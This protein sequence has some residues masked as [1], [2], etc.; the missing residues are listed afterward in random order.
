MAKEG[1]TTIYNEI[2]SQEKLKEVNKENL[3]LEEDFKKGIWKEGSS[4]ERRFKITNKQSKWYGKTYDTLSQED[5]DFFDDYIFSLTIFDSSEKKESKK[6]LYM[7][8]VFERIN[9]GSMKLSEQEVRNAVYSGITIDKIKEIAKSKSFVSLTKN[10]Q[11]ITD[12]KKDE[13]IVLR[14][15]TYYLAYL[16]HKNKKNCF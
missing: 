7:T 16:R 12:R 6:K 2:T 3:Q 4:A 15:A 11:K 9:T 13:E 14:F 8:E 10:D 5:K 1:R